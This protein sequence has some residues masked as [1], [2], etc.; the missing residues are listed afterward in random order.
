MQKTDILI[1]GGGLA[2]LTL[3]YR[4]L[5]YNYTVAV[6]DNNKTAT[7][8]RVS[9]GLINPITGKRL[10]KSW[11]IDDL[12]KSAS[13]F[14][15]QLEKIADTQLCS[16]RKMF[17]LIPNEDIFRQWSENLKIAQRE[18]YIE[19]KIAQLEMGGELKKFLVIKRVLAVNVSGVLTT[20]KEN[21]ARK[22]RIFH[23][24]FDHSRL[25]I[26]T[27]GLTYG[28]KTGC[29]RIIFCEGADGIRNP[30][31]GKL[32]FNLNKGEIITAK[33]QHFKFAQIL[34]HNIFLLPSGNE[35]VIIGSTYNWNELNSECTREAEKY[36]LKKAHILTGEKPITTDHKAA[37]RPS[38]KD[39][40]PFIGWLKENQRI[41]I[42]NGF[43]T[44]GC[45]L[46]P[47]WSRK[48]AES[49][50][51]ENELPDE[52]SISRFNL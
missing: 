17:R 29:S 4:L 1:V 43:G 14:Y 2:G 15:A 35:S 8:S 40:R 51:A 41:G 34:K 46:I 32:P 48:F 11:L 16:K 13:A 9:A 36:F 38:T 12:L 31:F 5:N 28:N 33:F 3:A 22:G 19:Q 45:S 39:R 26:R 49:I 24:I 27:D 7:A 10:V 50:L 18:G 37:I 30:F 42:F 23:E 52:V 25:K 47:Y 20:L 21:I 6:I 44:K